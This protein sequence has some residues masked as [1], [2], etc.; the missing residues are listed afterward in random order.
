VWDEENRL[1]YTATE[2]SYGFYI[3]DAAGERVAKQNG[4]MGQTNLNGNWWWQPYP[5]ASTIYA[6]PYLVATPQGYTKHYYAGSER[7]ASKTGEGGIVD[8]V[9]IILRLLTNLDIWKKTHD[10]LWTATFK[11]LPPEIRKEATCS[12]LYDLREVR[13]PE[14]ETYFYHPDHL[15]SA[16]WITNQEGH[17][18][19]HLQYLPFGETRIDQRKTGWSSRYSFSGKEKDE[20]SGYSYFGARYYNSDLSIWLS[21][22]PLA[23]AAPHQSPYA[24]CSNHPINRIDPNGMWDGDYYNT[25]GTWLGWDGINDG[26]IYIVDNYYDQNFISWN[27]DM[28]Y[29]AP[30]YLVPSAMELPDIS[31]RQEMLDEMIAADKANPFAEHGG[32]YGKQWNGENFEPALSKAPSGP[33]YDP[34]ISNQTVTGPDI[35]VA[36]TKNNFAPQGSYHSHPS[37]TCTPNGKPSF[38]QDV[39]A[40]DRIN[41][42]DRS[43]HYKNM[44]TRPSI[45][46]GMWDSKV[47]LY[48]I[49]GQT[50]TVPFNVFRTIR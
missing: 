31:V 34:C 43:N 23:S 21:V 9:G 18:I 19:Q 3:Y 49:K 6:S 50:A 46:F 5:K 36:L 17:P 48:D 12:A 32:A 24:Y 1:M 10:R 35:N 33:N 25:D 45:V 42:I 28:G 44:R 8:I 30:A 7:I 13:G 27:N 41:L 16:A 20:E 40:A 14:K 38:Q 29:M 26:R 22:D 15:G 4:S 2:Q 11:A 47:R 37:G 39:S